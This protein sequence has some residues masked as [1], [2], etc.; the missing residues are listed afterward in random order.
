M[1]ESNVYLKKGEDEQLVLEDVVLIKPAPGGLYLEDI[2]GRVREISGRIELI[3][4]MNHR[5]IVTGQ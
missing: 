4:L 5:I 2:L 1:C 3:D